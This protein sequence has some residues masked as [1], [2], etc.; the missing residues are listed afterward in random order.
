V[1]IPAPRRPSRWSSA[2]SGTL[3]RVAVGVVLVALVAWPERHE[4]VWQSPIF[5]VD[6]ECG[7]FI[8]GEFRS[9]RSMRDLA[10]DPAQRIFYD[11][12]YLEARRE[13][14]RR[15]REVGRISCYEYLTPE[16]T[17]RD[18]GLHVVVDIVNEL[19]DGVTGRTRTLIFRRR[20]GT[21]AP[22][23]KAAPHSESPGGSSV[24]LRRE[25]REAPFVLRPRIE[26]EDWMLD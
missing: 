13:R 7:F 2:C 10:S 6:D 22:T 4:P 8:G 23:P 20:G 11:P 16:W 5:I 1:E 17:Y 21:A 25:P 12:S 3:V 15:A 14:E 9:A 24:P 18:A 19:I 26:D